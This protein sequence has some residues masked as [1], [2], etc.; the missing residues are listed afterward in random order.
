[1]KHTERQE[2]VGED[3]PLP[4]GRIAVLEEC[5]GIDQEASRNKKLTK[6]GKAFDLILLRR[7]ISLDSKIL[8]KQEDL[9]GLL[10]G[11]YDYLLMKIRKSLHGD[12]IPLKLTCGTCKEESNWEIDLNDVPIKLYPKQ[13][14]ELIEEFL[15]DTPRGRKVVL[16]HAHHGDTL[17]LIRRDNP[18]QSEFMLVRVKLIDDVPVSLRILQDLPAIEYNFI[19]E[20]LDEYSYGPDTVVRFKCPDCG[21]ELITR[22]E[23][24]T[25]FFYPDSM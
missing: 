21:Q 16:K 14:G 4:S 10:V 22:L 12:I 1:M 24:E 6:Q 3:I 2:R 17:G 19:W 15:I 18:S 7:L 8:V 23:M 9:N 25:G 13:D 11:D 5:R 20:K